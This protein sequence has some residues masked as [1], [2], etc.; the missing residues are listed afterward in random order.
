MKIQFG[1][2]D[3]LVPFPVVLVVSGTYDK[4]NVIT[5]GKVGSVASNPP[6]L[7]VSIKRERYSMQL[8]RDGGEFSVNTPPSFLCTKTD[9][10][11]IVSGAKQDKIMTVKLS[12]MRSTYIAPP[13][14]RECPFNLECK[15]VKE[16]EL[17]D[18]VLFMG[19]VLETHIDEDC[20]E[21][22]KRGVIDVEKIDPLVYIGSAREYRVIGNHVGN[23]FQD[24]KLY[25]E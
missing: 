6:I 12:V 5:I 20:L 11:G 16:V 7:G 24:G 3:E 8:V 21:D 18:W 25:C 10:C 9:Y 13:I 4:P 2:K 1:P 23:G 17:G 15:V 14:I 22:K 19:E